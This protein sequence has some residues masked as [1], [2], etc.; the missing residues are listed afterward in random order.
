[1][2]QAARNFIVLLAALVCLGL[3]VPAQACNVPVFRYALERW[4]PDSYE[5]LVYHR[6]ALSDADQQVITLLND[7]IDAGGHNVTLTRVDL[8]QTLDERQQ[9]IFDHQQNAQL[10][11]LV[12][13]YPEYLGIQP[14]VWSGKLTRETVESLLD[15]P[16]R[17]ELTKRILA[18]ETTV[19]LLLEGQDEAENTAA[20][21][22][23]EAEIKKL[24]AE[25]KLPELTDSPEDE[26]ATA[27]PPLKIAFSVLPI[28]RTDPR[29]EL[30]RKMLIGS[31]SDLAERSDPMVFPVF[32]RGR[33]LFALIGPGIT[34]LNIGDSATFLTGPCSCQVKELNP[35][36]DLLLANRFDE[37]IGSSL[38]TD[39]LLPDAAGTEVPIP[40]G[41]SS[42]AA[43][44]SPNTPTVSAPPTQTTPARLVVQHSLLP[45]MSWA[46]LLIIGGG[47]FL[48]LVVVIAS[49]SVLFSNRA[50][51]QGS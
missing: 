34:E 20:R 6:G 23:L 45:P 12:V 32:G 7:Q 4:R 42:A 22:R 19:W 50:K 48:L 14:D 15:S 26:I 46:G 24:T 44:A 21:Q 37:V 1:M 5:L 31:E 11:W 30:L 2:K 47:G 27:G 33:A 13:R 16:V 49:L 18:G 41:P 39:M 8:E 29:E 35:G 36:F 43:A 25:L 17:S 38:L 10:P 9:A 51:Q 28:S 3:A 40:P